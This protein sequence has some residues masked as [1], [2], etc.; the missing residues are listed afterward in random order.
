MDKAMACLVVAIAA[1]MLLIMAPSES[2]D[3]DWRARE[4]ACDRD[5]KRLGVVGVT[6]FCV[7]R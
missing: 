7:V 3:T 1:M 6:P 4:A 2:A 5:G